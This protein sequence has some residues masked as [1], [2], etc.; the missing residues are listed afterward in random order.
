M[1]KI[2][3]RNAFTLIELLVVI[4]VIS[5]LI[6]LTLPAVQSVRRSAQSLS[7]KN[8][9]KNIGLAVANFQTSVKYYPPSFEVPPGETV[10]GS[11][12][13]HARIMPYM[14]E[15]NAH[16]RI[17]FSADWHE[18][19][20]TGIPAY[21][22]PLY[23]CPSESNTIVRQKDGGDYVYG[24]N[25]GFNLG[26]WLIHDPVSGS[27]GD[28]SFRV[29]K[30]MRPRDFL[31]DGLTNSLGAVDVKMFTSYIRNVDTIDPTLPATPDH[32]EGVTGELKL[33]PAHDRNT[34]HTVWC[35]GRVHHTGFTTVYTPN[36]LVPYTYN[37]ELYDIDFSSQQEGRDLTRP[38]YA[39]VT[40]R[41]YH[42]AGVNAM[43]MDGSVRFISDSITLDVWRALGTANNGEVIDSSVLE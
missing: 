7:C 22:A 18:Q 31:T 9:L 34:G 39:A 6:G 15:D 23:T 12:S 38:T 14:E 4:A 19:V 2:S 8:N 5:I 41:S 11:W 43:F 28:G 24:T 13:I 17:D 35:D 21:A 25:Y 26:S 37:G 1:Q 36:T 30:K 29:N 27:N 42:D 40:A 32:F 3:S 33:G 20:D 10:R 16:E